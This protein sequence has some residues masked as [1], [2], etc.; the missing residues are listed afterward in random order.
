MRAVSGRGGHGPRADDAAPDVSETPR[1]RA[2]FRRAPQNSRGS[3]PPPP[4]LPR[5]SAPPRRLSRENPVQNERLLVE[6][7]FWT[8]PLVVV[9]LHPVPGDAEPVEDPAKLGVAPAHLAL[10]RVGGLGEHGLGSRRARLVAR[11]RRVHAGRRARSARLSAAAISASAAA[12]TAG[13]LARRRGGGGGGGFTRAVAHRLVRG[14]LRAG[15]LHALA[16]HARHSARSAIADASEPED[17]PRRI[18]PATVS[19]PSSTRLVARARAPCRGSAARSD[20]AAAAAKAGP[21][22]ACFAPRRRT[23]RRRRRARWTRPRRAAP[24]ARPRPSEPRRDRHELRA[25][26]FELARRRLRRRR[27]R[28]APRRR[29]LSASRAAPS[30]TRRATPSTRADASPGRMP[31]LAPPPYPYAAKSARTPPR[32]RR[33]RDPIAVPVPRVPFPFPFPVPVPV[34]L[35]PRETAARTSRGGIAPAYHGTSPGQHLRPRPRS[36]RASADSVF[37]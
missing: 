26:Q 15:P 8:T 18:R 20:A 30:G 36:A 14:G 4:P 34:R 27:R 24:R 35:G 21:G 29:A 7:G 19:A 6:P 1:R 5:R 16:R 3:P 2:A 17:V 9:A 25:L 12:T 11:R 23:P 10:E 22:A 32:S 33:A 37:S 13:D 31:G 28:L